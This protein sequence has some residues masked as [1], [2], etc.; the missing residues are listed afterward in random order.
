MYEY[1]CTVERCLDGDTVDAVIDL[2]FDCWYKS[3]VRL[4]GINAPELRGATR[5]AA[6]QARRFLEGELSKGPIVILTELR[7]DKDKY[8]RVLGTLLV[9]G[10]NVNRR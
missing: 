10:V 6:E 9:N 1:R 8:G 4:K 2:G 3:P 7:K 5:E